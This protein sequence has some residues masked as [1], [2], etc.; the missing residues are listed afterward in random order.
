MPE[1]KRAR[2]RK[3]FRHQ[4]RHRQ[5]H[6]LGQRQRPADEGHLPQ[7]RAGGRQELLSLEH[8]GTADL[9]RD[10]R[11]AR[12]PPRARGHASTSWSR[13]TPRPTRATCRKWPRAATSSTTRPGRAPALLMRDDVTVLGVP[14][15]R[16]CNENF[17]GV[18]TRILMKNICYAGVLAALCDAGPGHHP[19]AAGRD[20]RQEAAAG[21][22]QHEGDPAR[23]RL[24]ARSTSPAR[25]RCASR[26][27]MPPAGHIIIDGNTAAG[28][29]LRLRRRHG[30]APG[31]RSRP[32][33]R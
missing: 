7:R 3:R 25:C 28:A 20:L 15:A 17:Q 14:L 4:D 32:R 29:R 6:R 22:R 2:P 19:R 33:P 16:L 11:H 31:I 13:S 1:R 24:C 8:P 27:W 21:G 9:V 12:R 18:R 5:R 30:R 26:R 23:L 10:P